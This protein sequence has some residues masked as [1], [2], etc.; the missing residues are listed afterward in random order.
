MLLFIKKLLCKYFGHNWQKK[1]E[2]TDVKHYGA[3]TTWV[4][5]R[6][7]DTTKTY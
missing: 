6:C 1:I 2:S 7:G 5:K 3:S 4:C